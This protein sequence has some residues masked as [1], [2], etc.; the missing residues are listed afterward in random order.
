MVQ[1][2]PV[3]LAAPVLLAHRPFPWFDPLGMAA[4]VYFI[5]GSDT[6]VGKTVLTVLLVRRLRERGLAGLAV[7]PLCSGGRTDARLLW[8]AQDRV[9]SLDQVNPWHFRAP[10]AP[11]LAARREGQDVRL[12]QVVAYLDRLRSCGEVLLVEGAGGLL[13][14][15]GEDF[16]ACDLIA[17]L[18]ARPVVVCPNRLGAVNQ[19][20]LVLAALPR[21][22]A[23]SAQVVLMA[24]RNPDSAAASNPGLLRELTGPERVHVLSWLAKPEILGREPLGPGVRRTLD[25]LAGLGP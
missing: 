16:N 19:A 12:R 23:R 11:L 24:R 21:S 4:D 18:R 22:A 7:K 5:T 1:R 8:Q 2:N 17:A 20:L 13:S 15:L 10:L 3:K 25:R 6:G 9:L 14:P